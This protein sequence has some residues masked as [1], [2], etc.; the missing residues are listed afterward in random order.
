MPRLFHM[1]SPRCAALLRRHLVWLFMALA[2]PLIGA[3]AAP[4][5]VAAISGISPEMASMHAP[6]ERTPDKHPIVIAM[7]GEAGLEESRPPRQRVPVDIDAGIRA[8]VPRQ[9]HVFLAA[10]AETVLQHALA[11]SQAYPREPHLR[12]N[13]SHA[14]PLA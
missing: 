7:T 11:R 9:D 8:A 6:G 5:G 14:P 1:A 2:L 13:H 12:L 3:A 10:A 4:S